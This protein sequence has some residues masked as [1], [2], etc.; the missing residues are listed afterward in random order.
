M[1]LSNNITVQ[2]EEIKEYFDDSGGED[3]GSKENIQSPAMALSVTRLITEAELWAAL[4]ER[5][6]VDRLVSR[7]F[8]SNDLA[9][10]ERP[11]PNLP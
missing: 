5:S 2:I 6:V 10:S 8:N 9:I 3:F 7:Y 4:P 11:Y 1:P